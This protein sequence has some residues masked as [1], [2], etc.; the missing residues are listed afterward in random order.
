[1]VASRSY[2]VPADAQL[3]RANFQGPRYLADLQA[4]LHSLDGALDWA[5]TSH[6]TSAMLRLVTALGLF[7]E[8][9]GHL[10]HGGRCA[11]PAPA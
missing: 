4:N 7:C 5:E 1:M 8:L 2:G 3:S 11:T 6:E 9:G 10:A